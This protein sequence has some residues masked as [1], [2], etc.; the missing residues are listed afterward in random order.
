MVTPRYSFQCLTVDCVRRQDWSALVGDTVIDTWTELHL[1][2]RFSIYR[3]SRSCCMSAVS[4]TD[5]T[6]R[7]RT[8]SSA[9][10]LVVEEREVQSGMS[11]M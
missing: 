3:A 1:P 8:V 4:S 9:N 5:D 11:F 7:Q 6:L 2:C 10:N